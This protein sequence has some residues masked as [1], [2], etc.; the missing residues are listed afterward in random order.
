MPDEIKYNQLAPEMLE[1]LPRGAFLSVRSGDRINTMTIGW[2]A[3]GFIWQRPV[4]MVMVRYSRFTHE[5]IQ[6]S[7]EFSVCVPL[8]S[9]FKKELALAGTKSGRD[10]DKFKAFKLE[11]VPGAK[12][13]APVI[14]DCGL[15]YECKIVFRQP[16]NPDNLDQDIKA[17]YYDDNDYHVLYFGEILSCYKNG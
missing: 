14:G 11:V 7:P 8:N 3:L 4:M 6:N 1:Q 9:G 13:N 10:I 5:L 15:V 2:G 16:M 17:K 12:T